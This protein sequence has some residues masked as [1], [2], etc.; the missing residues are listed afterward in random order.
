MCV[1]GFVQEPGGPWFP[2]QGRAERGGPWVER[3]LPCGVHG[4]LPPPPQLVLRMRGSGLLLSV[5]RKHAGKFSQALL[6]TES[7]LERGSPLRALCS[8]REHDGHV[9]QRC[10]GA[11]AASTACRDTV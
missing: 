7:E 2:G 4:A 1:C 9:L 6:V 8:I 3:I 11:H 5:P 10:P